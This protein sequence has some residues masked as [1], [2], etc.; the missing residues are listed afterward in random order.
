MSSDARILLIQERLTNDLTLGESHF[1]EFKSALDGPERKRRRKLSSVAKDIGETLVAFANADGGTLI[2]GAEDDGTISGVPYAEGDI[3][4]LRQA[5]KTH[6]HTD[7]PLPGVRTHTVSVADK[8]LLAFEVQKGTQYI[9]LTS[10]G[11]CLQRRD[12]STLPVASEQIRFER[13]EQLSRE[14]D[15]RWVDGAT[16]ADLN[17]DLLARVA[18]RVSP[19]LSMEKC[20]QALGLAEFVA[21]SLRLRTAALLLFSSNIVRWHPRSE[22]RLLR[23]AGTE[24]L[25]GADYNVQQ[26]ETQSGNVLQLLSEGWEQIR[27]FLVQKRLAG[28]TFQLQAAYPEDVCREAFVNAIAH[29]DYSIEGRPIEVLVFNDRLEI[30]NPGRLL[31][32]VKLS[33]LRKGTG[34]HDSRNTYIAR[35]LRELD[36]MQE[37]GE[38]IRRI[39]ALMNGHELAPPDIDSV[40]HSFSITFSQ[41]NIFSPSE[42]IWLD[43]FGEFNLSREEK[44]IVLLGRGGR[45]ISTNQIWETLNLVDTEDY[46]QLVESLQT[47]GLLWSEITKRVAANIARRQ[48]ITTRDVPRFA[49]RA[50]DVAL[51][52]QFEVVEAL[53]EMGPLNQVR[54]AHFE[55]IR[56]KLSDH[57]LYRGIVKIRQL[58]HWLQLV[59]S[60]GAPTERLRKVWADGEG[61]H[62]TPELDVEA[63][64]TTS[65]T[66]ARDIYVGNLD[67][68]A[69]ESDLRSVFG[70]VGEV[71]DV[72]IPK[73]YLTGHSRGY[74]FVRM[75][76]SATSLKA[77]AEINGQSLRD[78]PLKLGWSFRQQD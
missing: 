22:V 30:R 58:L 10:D 20:L 45:L 27:Q 65:L 19:G 75:V 40:D 53:M 29:R 78:R 8:A 42:Q 47:K 71:L 6:V 48:G 50:P 32:T 69:T 55:R 63:R 24:V 4:V 9:H 15:R 52:D 72:S 74:A 34:V 54:N 77:F 76:D 66:P 36:Y 62:P 61:S 33:E 31:S 37:M 49:I 73:D 64:P 2:V 67:Y 59:D 11:R 23:I 60:G 39:G 51:R 57:N 16:V 17:R 41:R 5:P 12:T 18:E 1:R 26:D 21:G 38:G 25:T 56:G 14:Y 3:E 70:R 28:G 13:H 35:V 43:A 44:L 46:R 7:T 68:G